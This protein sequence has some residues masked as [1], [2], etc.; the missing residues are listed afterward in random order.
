MSWSFHLD[1]R[2]LSPGPWSLS[3][4][5]WLGPT[6]GQLRSW[7]CK[8]TIINPL[9]SCANRAELTTAAPQSGSSHSIINSSNSLVQ[10]AVSGLISELMT[11]RNGH[12]EIIQHTQPQTL[13]SLAGG[14]RQRIVLQMGCPDKQITW[15]AACSI[16]IYVLCFW[17]RP[18]RGWPIQTFWIME[19]N[20]R[21]QG[22]WSEYT[23]LNL[24]C[25]V[26]DT[27]SR[28][29]RQLPRLRKAL[30]KL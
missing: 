28:L 13:N 16:L 1:A 29:T 23:N 2:W 26:G 7:E 10:C 20:E 5:D 9:A 11:T 15:L 17:L 12:T 30:Q 14:L 21:E 18:W 27:M 8:W 22:Q 24:L 6:F 19:D 3:V 4:S 25:G